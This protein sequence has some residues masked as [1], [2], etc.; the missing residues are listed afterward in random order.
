MNR[1]VRL[2]AIKDNE[3]N[4]VCPIRFLL[5]LAL[6]RG[7]VSGSTISEVLSTA[8]RRTD[9]TV[10]WTHGE[11]PVMV[12]Q[13]PHSGRWGTL[14]SLAQL[15]SLKPLVAHPSLPVTEF[16]PRRPVY[17]PV[18]KNNTE[19]TSSI[20]RQTMIPGSPRGSIN[21][22]SADSC[23]LIRKTLSGESIMSEMRQLGNAT[24]RTTL[25]ASVLQRCAK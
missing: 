21:F 9:K 15:A 18:R 6:R 16:A 1:I 7:N 2:E 11:R 13:K 3:N 19:V 10:K 8:Y 22:V 25:L 4:I 20:V 14:C 17:S 5:I 24:K 23:P 12:A